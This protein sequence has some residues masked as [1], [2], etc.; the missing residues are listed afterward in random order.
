MY[1]RKKQKAGPKLVPDRTV[2]GG[3]AKKDEKPDRVMWDGPIKKDMEEDE[4]GQGPHGD[5]AAGA[6]SV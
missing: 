1:P 4:Q 2:C 5:N 3:R 6:G